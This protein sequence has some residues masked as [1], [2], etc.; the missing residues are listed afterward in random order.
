[1]RSLQV[2]LMIKQPVDQKSCVADQKMG[3]YSLRLAMIY[4]TSGE[5]GFHHSEAKKEEK[6]AQIDEL[7]A[8]IRENGEAEAAEAAARG[9][10]AR[11]R[12]ENAGTTGA[13]D[14]AVQVDAQSAAAGEMDTALTGEVKNIL[15]KLN[16][17]SED[18]KG[19]KVDDFT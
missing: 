12:K 16:L 10:A 17:L 4:R 8:R 1:M 6:Q 5:I 15:N 11:Q 3:S 14:T 7:Q 13:T 2:E 9:R 18:I 19:A